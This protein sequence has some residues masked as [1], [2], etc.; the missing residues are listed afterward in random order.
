MAELA[1]HVCAALLESETEDQDGDLL[2]ECVV[3]KFVVVAEV[4]R[5]NGDRWLCQRSG[6]MAGERIMSWEAIG[7]LRVAM[8]IM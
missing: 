8:G 2:T 3:T 7:M 6:A 4:M 5:P 1:K